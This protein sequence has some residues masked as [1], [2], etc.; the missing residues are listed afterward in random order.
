MTPEEELHYVREQLNQYT[1]CLKLCIEI[2]SGVCDGNITL[3]QMKNFRDNMDQLG[4]QI[5]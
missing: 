1:Y 5:Q 3:Q 4:G 2:I